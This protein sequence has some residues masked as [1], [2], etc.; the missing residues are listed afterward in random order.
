MGAGTGG[1]PGGDK[2]EVA[3]EAPTTAAAAV[4][5]EESD[6]DDMGLSL[7]D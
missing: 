3:L 1:A 7:F 2:P 5:E 4:E 6:D